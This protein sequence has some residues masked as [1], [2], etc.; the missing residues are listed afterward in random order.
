[1]V[2]MI[3]QCYVL[4]LV[5]FILSVLRMLIIIGL[6]MLLANLKQLTY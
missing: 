6:F 3:E 2:V 5:I 4:V 1:M